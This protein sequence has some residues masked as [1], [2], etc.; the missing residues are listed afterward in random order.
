MR[1][2][3]DHGALVSKATEL[4]REVE[5][6]ALDARVEAR[7]ELVRDEKNANLRRPSSFTRALRAALRRTSWVAAARPRTVHVA[8]PTSTRAGAR[9]RSRSPRRPPAAVRRT[10]PRFARP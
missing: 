7:E 2:T 9:T 10:A 1:G 4:R 6:Q 3:G 5:R 8:P